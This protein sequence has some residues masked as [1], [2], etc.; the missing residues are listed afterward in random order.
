MVIYGKITSKIENKTQPSLC[1][2]TWL[3][4]HLRVSTNHKYRI[5]KDVFFQPD[6]LKTWRFVNLTFCKPDVLK[7]WRFVNLT[8]QTFWNRTFWNLTFCGCTFS[9]SRAG[10]LSSECTT[11]SFLGLT[12]VRT[13]IL[14]LSP[15]RSGEKLRLECVTDS[16]LGF[17]RPPS[18]ISPYV[19][20]SMLPPPPPSTWWIWNMPSLERGAKAAILDF[21]LCT[22]YHA[23]SLYLVELEHAELGAWRYG[24]H[25][26]FHPMWALACS[27]LLPGGAG[28]CW[29]WSV[30]LRPPS[31]I[32]PYV[33]PNMLP[34]PLV[35]LEH[36]E[37]DAWR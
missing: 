21:T 29:A 28:T 34:P 2:Q 26:G 24:R 25:L 5:Y 6:V 18:W 32:S 10:T 17:L 9:L 37:L 8:F 19:R 14:P 16:F 23:P 7:T 3:Q 33:S 31:W 27:L 35:E 13:C 11:D 30:A 36:A 1:L 4:Q 15:G 22:P 20:P 12:N